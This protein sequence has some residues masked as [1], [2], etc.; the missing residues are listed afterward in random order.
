LA[1]S[2]AVQDAQAGFE[3]HD[4]VSAF[5]LPR[6]AVV[7]GGEITVQPVADVP[8]LMLNVGRI[9][10][11]HGGSA[12][13]VRKEWVTTSS[14][15]KPENLEPRWKRVTNVGPVAIF[16]NTRVLPRAWLARN[17]RVV[18][19][20]EQLTIIRSGKM[21]DGSA[22][23]PLE[24]VLVERTT[25]TPILNEEAPPGRVEF[26]RQEPNRVEIKTESSVPSVLVLAANH[27]PG[28]QA[29]VD[30]RRVKILRVNYNQRGVTLP[31]GR[32]T[33]M[34]N[35]QPRSVQ[36]GIMISLVTLVSLL[37]W[38][39]AGRTWSRPAPAPEDE[40]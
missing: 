5:S 20:D 40:T 37:G 1:T 7:I 34:F 18:A 8:N 12:L 4:Y 9:S 17:E 35:Y 29:Q 2:H 25:G 19:V 33:V 31:R 28:W 3:G 36:A 30:G 15:P 32:H 11:L 38:V 14:S 22:W 23:D 10:L 16:E 39:A 13:P 24:Q 21:S 26:V 6:P 27:Y